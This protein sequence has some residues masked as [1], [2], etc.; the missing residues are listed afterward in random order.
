MSCSRRHPYLAGWVVVAALAFS[1]ATVVAG[2]AQTTDVT[3]RATR[4]DP[5]PAADTEAVTVVRPRGDR[6]VGTVADSVRG[7]AGVSVQQTTPGQGTLFVRGLSGREIVHLVDGVRVNSTVF[8]AGNNPQLGLVDPYSIA[9]IEIVRGAG[10]VLHGS[11]ALGGVVSMNGVTPE[12]APTPRYQLSYVALGSSNPTGGVARVAA[13]GRW[14]SLAMQ[15]GVTLGA[16]GD[17]TP[18]QRVRTPD[19]TSYAGL[20]YPAAGRPVPRLALSQSG[21]STSFVGSDFVAH[22]A[23]GRASVVVRLGGMFRPESERVDEIT[24]RFKRD[25]PARHTSEL[26]P[27]HRLAASMRV[28]SRYDDGPIRSLLALVAWQQ[29][30]DT[31]IRRN[32]D[33]QC[34]ESGAA[35][36]VDPS[37]CTSTLRLVPSTT[38]L[39]DRSRADAISARVEARSGRRGDLISGV[40]GADVAHETVTASA[41]EYEGE[42]KRAAAA[43]FPD[44]SSQTQAGVFALVEAH[45]ARDLFVSVGGRGALFALAVRARSA[46]D[47]TPAFQR[48]NVAMAA[49]FGVRWAAVPGISWVANVGR[50][51]RAPNVQDFATLGPRAGN[52]YQLPSPDVQPEHSLSV[53]TGV[54]ANI[55]GLRAEVFVFGVRVS[56]AVV[57]VP[58]SLAG[59]AT[60]DAGEQYVVAA[61]ASSVTLW[62]V[63]GSVRAR[64]AGRYLLSGTY[65]AMRGNQH[66]VA[67]ADGPRET[68]A[69][70]VPPAQATLGVLAD[71]SSSVGVE[72]FARGRLAQQRLNDPTNLT[73][74]RIP[75]G[76]TPGYVTCHARVTWNAADSLHLWVAAD[77][78][79]DA[80]ALEHG[81]GFYLPGRAVSAGVR[82]SL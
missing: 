67:G 48:T 27:S 75:E 44:G 65:L 47:P 15:L 32:W 33:K 70:R 55:D 43:R 31:T 8:R 29:L 3:V 12:W 25:V 54:R 11:D 13:Q 10:S 14:P 41:F 42:Q 28:A 20:E 39:R 30:A 59:R 5:D 6:H 7:E 72:L 51:F 36:A 77:N 68:P 61:N 2:D 46:P 69:D 79:F 40:L 74:N 23:L 50:G 24:P 18:G 9:R 45:V 37:D 76:G 73:D 58:R 52:R 1:P 35:S 81:S 49:Y 60:N 57:V 80:L 66:N 64:L 71:V 34:I 56:D 82:G 17:V 22:G 19:R 16:A 63:E 53:D 21:T 62:G 78:L 26:T 4:A 38:E